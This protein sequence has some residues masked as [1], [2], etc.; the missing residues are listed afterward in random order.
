MIKIMPRLIG[1]TACLLLI[2]VLIPSHQIKKSQTPEISGIE[3]DE[4]GSEI[5]L[6]S[7]CEKQKDESR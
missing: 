4:S 1:G 3:T 7:A 2:S 6:S 5:F